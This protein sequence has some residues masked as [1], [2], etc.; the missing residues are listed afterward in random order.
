[1]TRFCLVAL[2]TLSLTACA[3][4]GTPTLDPRVQVAA[5]NEADRLNAIAATQAQEAQDRAFNHGQTETALPFALA[6]MERQAALADIA[7]TQAWNDATAT[8]SVRS[9]EA[10]FSAVV[11]PTQIAAVG[12]A[13][14]VYAETD[15]AK[16]ESARST[17]NLIGLAALGF[18]V[19]MLIGCY[20]L[21]GIVRADVK[22][23]N[24][25]AE[26][27][28]EVVGGILVLPP[29]YT[30]HPI[31]MAARALP[32]PAEIEERTIGGQANGKPRFIE[33][34]QP[35]NEHEKRWR[36]ILDASC[37]IFEQHGFSSADLCGKGKPFASPSYWMD[38][39]DRLVD[40]GLILKE[41][42]APTL[43]VGEWA[44]IRARI[45]DATHPLK[46]PAYLPPHL[47]AF[48]P[49]KMVKLR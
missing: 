35:V 22:R 16:L 28:P 37:F 7:V 4:A 10:A 47:R 21:T 32:A 8:A 19:G 43:P 23:R 15:K 40:N 24:N 33:V 26:A 36:E 11:I 29:G 17:N 34:S 18:I 38:V 48:D 27:R 14:A 5:M 30:Q 46:L 20:W 2:L 49:S 3:N 12:T 45:Q 9:T 44:D 1:M 42:G 13:L 25:L 31:V 39:T 41:H 6:E